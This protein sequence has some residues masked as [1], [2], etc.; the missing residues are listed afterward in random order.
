MDL[1]GTLPILLP[2]AVEWAEM[3]QVDILAFGRSL[4]ADEISTAR[5]VGVK[6]L[7]RFGLKRY[8]VFRSLPTAY[9]L[10]QRLSPDCSP[11][12]QD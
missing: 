3:Q 8:R 2:K 9:W 7:K 5:A 12:K 10:K 11:I 1:Q 6:H 4:T